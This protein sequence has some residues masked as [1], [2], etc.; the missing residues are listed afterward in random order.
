[1]LAAAIAA[2]NI[3]LQIF[4][5]GGGCTTLGALDNMYRHNISILSDYHFVDL[6]SYKEHLYNFGIDSKKIF[7]NAEEFIKAIIKLKP[8]STKGNY[9]KSIFMSSTMSPSISIDYKV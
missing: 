9:I 7:E 8:S 2:R 5:I 3:G 6:I 1:M 4:H